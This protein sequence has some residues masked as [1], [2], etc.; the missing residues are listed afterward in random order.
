MEYLRVTKGNKNS[1]RVTIPRRS[2]LY[3]CK[4]VR[5]MTLE[6]EKM[7]YKNVVLNKRSRQKWINLSSLDGVK[8]SDYIKVYAGKKEK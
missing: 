4:N 1:F 6:D 7:G 3:D 8:L 2:K 5:L